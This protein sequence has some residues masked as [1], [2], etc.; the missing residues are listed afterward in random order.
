MRVLISEIFV[1]NPNNGVYK[2][3]KIVVIFGG[4]NRFNSLYCAVN[5]HPRSTIN[6]I[7]LDVRSNT[8]FATFAR[9]EIYSN[10]IFFTKICMCTKMSGIQGI[11]Q[12]PKHVFKK[13]FVNL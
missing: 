8:R 2:K 5:L 6:H 7:F 12:I 13:M 9:H 3:N 4:I 11:L 10:F 1:W